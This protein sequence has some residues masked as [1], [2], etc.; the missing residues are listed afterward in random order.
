[1]KKEKDHKR[2]GGGKRERRV[3]RGEI[4][5]EGISNQINGK[6]CG[7]RGVTSRRGSKKTKCICGIGSNG[8]WDRQPKDVRQKRKKAGYNN[9]GKVGGV[10]MGRQMN[11][12]RSGGR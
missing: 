10:G 11:C 4:E 5:K 8:Q 12:H 3:W 1:V 7:E 9:M 6:K 2:G